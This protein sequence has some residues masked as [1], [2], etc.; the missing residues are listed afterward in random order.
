M[1][2]AVK[3]ILNRLY[4]QYKPVRFN[5]IL[6]EDLKEI[7]LLVQ[8]TEDVQEEITKYLTNLFISDF[9]NLGGDKH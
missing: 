6:T 8:L 5:Q 2:H 3:I 9:K 7:S 1:P 4:K